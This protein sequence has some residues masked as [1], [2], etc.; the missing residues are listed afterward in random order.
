MQLEL[1][2]IQLKKSGMQIGKKSFQNLLVTMAL[3]KKP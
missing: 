2:L 3:E 1:N